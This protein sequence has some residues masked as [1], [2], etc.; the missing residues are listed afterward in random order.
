MG[1]EA[2][3]T[4]WLLW[5]LLLYTSRCRCPGVSLHLYL[6]GKSPVVQLLGRRAGLF[7]TLWGT[8]TQFSR[9][10]ATVLAEKS[11]DIP[12][13]VRF[14]ITNCFSFPFFS[15]LFFFS[16]FK[17]LLF[18]FIFDLLLCLGVKLFGFLL[19][20]TGNASWACRPVFFPRLGKFLGILSSNKFFTLFSLLFLGP[21]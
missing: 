12:V 8:S 19:F 6:W 17:I 11:T 3:S 13:V 18:S 1:T 15:F 9:V 2:P 20:G 16:A 21:L 7:L 10:H 5:T 14:D 4:V